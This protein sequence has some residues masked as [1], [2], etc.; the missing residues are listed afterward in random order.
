MKQLSIVFML[1]LLFTACSK[2]ELKLTPEYPNMVK[3]GGFEDPIMSLDYW[4]FDGEGVITLS[5]DEVF[6]GDYSMKVVP[7]EC[8]EIVY[9][10]DLP[11]ELEATY[12]LTFYTKISELTQ[13]CITDFYLFLKQDESIVF[14][15]NISASESPEWTRKVAYIKTEQSAPMQLH[16]FT[17]NASILIDDIKFRRIQEL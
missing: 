4:Q 6:S 14:E 1:L 17:G 11:V 8:M 13:N 9:N 2:E 5:E 10:E 7:S 3:N 12:E 16:I 15:M